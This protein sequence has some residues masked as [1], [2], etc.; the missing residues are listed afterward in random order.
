[1]GIRALILNQR[2]WRHQRRYGQERLVILRDH[3]NLQG[4]NSADGREM[5]SALGRD[6]LI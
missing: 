6:S 3:I 5:T 2:R 1:M 4:Q